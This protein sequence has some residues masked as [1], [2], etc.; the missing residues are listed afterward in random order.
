MINNGSIAGYKMIDKVINSDGSFLITYEVSVS[1]TQLSSFVV[2]SGGSTELQGGLFAN[3]IKLME[4]N[5][6]AEL[7]SIKDLL[8]ISYKLLKTS[9]DYEIKNGSPVNDNGV[10]DVSLDISIKKNN[11]YNNFTKFFY[12][13]LKSLSMNS[14]DVVA[15]TQLNKKLYSVGLFDNSKV[16]HSTPMIDF[17]KFDKTFLSKLP[18]N[19]DYKY[20][21]VNIQDNQSVNLIASSNKEALK[22]AEKMNNYN[23]VSGMNEEVRKLMG[24]KRFFTSSSESQINHII[25]RSEKSYILL[26]SFIFQIPLFIHE[27]QIDNGINVV[28]FSKIKT[29]KD[30]YY[31][32]DINQNFRLSDWESKFSISFIKYMDIIYFSGFTKK[33]INEKNIT[34]FNISD[35]NTNN[36]KKTFFKSFQNKSLDNKMIFLNNENISSNNNDGNYFNY[37]DLLFASYIEFQKSMFDL[38]QKYNVNGVNTSYILNESFPLQLTLVG[39][40]NNVVF[41]M[42]IINSLT[43]D[44]IAKVNKFKI[45]AINQNK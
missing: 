33:E 23:S 41:K 4:L 38:Q 36:G 39:D 10:W 27:F 29:D 15:Y 44:E 19:F 9:F 28:N 8:D 24:S 13:T 1:I 12:S 32:K 7:K 31:S 37:F 40:E 45:N 42:K 5:E 16:N 17:H 14:N 26:K 35:I 34:N 11:N 18:P 20:Y 22:F 43:T 25:L 30:D 2:N 3:N 21:T 6:K